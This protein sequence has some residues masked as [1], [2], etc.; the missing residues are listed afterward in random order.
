MTGPDIRWQHRFA[1]FRKAPAQLTR[2]MDQENLNEMEIQGLIQSFEYNLERSWNTIKSF[3]EYQGETGIQGSRD[4]FRTGI[5]RG[6]LSNGE[7]WMQMI[8]SR[9]LT[10]HTYSEIGRAH[11]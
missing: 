9:S 8:R 1:N 3:Y 7:D 11:V 4:A 2:I 6:L 5:E 10:V